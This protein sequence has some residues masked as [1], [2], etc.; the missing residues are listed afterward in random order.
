MWIF[1]FSKSTSLHKSANCSPVLKPVKNATAKNAFNR[2]LGAF[3]M[4]AL[5]SSKLKG[6]IALASCAFLS[7]ILK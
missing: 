4:S 3:S 5:T 7:V 2:R 6:L 1:L